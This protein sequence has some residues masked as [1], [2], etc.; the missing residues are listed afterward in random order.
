MST[1]RAPKQ[2]YDFG[3]KEHYRGAVW[4]GL[5]KC[6]ERWKAP[7]EARVALMPSQ[8]GV[9]IEVCEKVGFKREN[10]H[11]IDRNPAICAHLSRRYPGITTYGV[12]ASKA[13]E[14]MSRRGVEIDAANLDFCNCVGDKLFDELEAIRNTHAVGALSAV[15]VTVLRGRE[16]RGWTDFLAGVGEEL[17]EDDPRIPLI[18][19]LQVGTHEWSVRDVTRLLAAVCWLPFT[20]RL[21]RCGV[22]KSAA[23]S[24]TMLWVVADSGFRE[25]VTLVGKRRILGVLDEFLRGQGEPQDWDRVCGLFDRSMATIEDSILIERMRWDSWAHRKMRGFDR[26]IQERLSELRQ[27]ATKQQEL[28]AHLKVAQ[29]R[30]KVFA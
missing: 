28:L 5:R 19:D 2:G 10:M 13:F 30:P 8:E 26:Q 24:Q 29:R 12:E 11:V 15:G 21:E 18:H 16:N 27:A 6:V 1:R 25:Y 9:E 23:G 20:V 4:G 17:S 14:R 7:G 22:Y 3:T